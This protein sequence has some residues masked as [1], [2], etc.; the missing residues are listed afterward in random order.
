MID[1]RGWQARASGLHD[2]QTQL[3][4]LAKQRRSFAVDFEAAL[5]DYEQVLAEHNLPIEVPCGFRPRDHRTDRGVHNDRIFWRLEELDVGAGVVHFRH[6]CGPDHW[7]GGV[8]LQTGR[9]RAASESLTVSLLF[10]THR[11]QWL[12]LTA[13]AGTSVV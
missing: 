11:T 8:D 3:T 10:F 4:A 5:A 9:R 12:T 2:V 7:A 6:K 13:L 1:A